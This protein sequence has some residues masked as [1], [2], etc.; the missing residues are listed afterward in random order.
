MTPNWMK[1]ELLAGYSPLMF[2]MAKVL[3]DDLQEK[4]D[5]NPLVVASH[6]IDEHGDSDTGVID[7]QPG[8]VNSM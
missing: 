6:A 2:L 4:L 5:V 1:E 8:K 7:A 3:P